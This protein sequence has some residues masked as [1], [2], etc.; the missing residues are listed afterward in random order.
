MHHKLLHNDAKKTIPVTRSRNQIEIPTEPDDSN[1]NTNDYTFNIH[2]VNYHS[3]LFQYIPVTLHNKG[4]NIRTY[5]FLDTGSS[6][7]LIEQGLADELN[8]TGKKQPLTLDGLQILV[9]TKI[10]L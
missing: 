3:V 1:R 2:R 7:T 8:L 10:R 9:V 4:L 5:A 6:S